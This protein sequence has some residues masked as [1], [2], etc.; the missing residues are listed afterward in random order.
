[1][2]VP[3]GPNVLCIHDIC[4][5]GRHGERPCEKSSVKFSRFNAKN[6]YLTFLGVIIGIFRCKILD[7]NFC[8][9]LYKI[10]TGSFPGADLKP[11]D[12][13]NE[14]IPKYFSDAVSALLNESV[15]SFSEFDQLLNRG[16][17]ALSF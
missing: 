3:E 1:M 8:V 12:E 11:I 9:C 15:S 2:V 10:S 6:A 14:S 17:N 16:F 13:C 4:R 7:P 5:G